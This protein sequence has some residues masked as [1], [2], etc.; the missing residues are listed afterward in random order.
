MWQARRITQ[1]VFNGPYGQRCAILIVS[2]RI[3]IFLDLS[4]HFPKILLKFQSQNIFFLFYR[5]VNQTK[6]LPKIM[7]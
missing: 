6:G 4:K 2:W 5:N 7:E 3:R 1:P